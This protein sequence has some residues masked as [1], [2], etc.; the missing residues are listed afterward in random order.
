VSP[1]LEEACLKELGYWLP[2]L[3]DHTTLGK[4]QE[5]VPCIAGSGV[6][7]L[8]A[9]ILT[10]L[11]LNLVLKTP[12]RILLRTNQFRCRDFPK[13][14]NKVRKISW[15]QYAVLHGSA[16]WHVTAAQSRLAV[17]RRI[18]ETCES[19]LRS[20]APMIEGAG[21]D[22][23]GATRQQVH[24][25]F[26]DDECT[27][28]LDSSGGFLFKRGLRTKILDA[29]LRENLAAALLWALLDPKDQRP[30]AL[31]DPMT[32]SGCFPL[33][34]LALTAVNTWS[35]FPF[36]AWPIFATACK[37]AGLEGYQDFLAEVR[38]AEGEC[39]FGAVRGSD[40]DPKAIATAQ[41]NLKNVL[42]TLK[43]TP[44]TPCLFFQA[45]AT[46]VEALRRMDCVGIA[47]LNPP[48]NRRLQARE[49]AQ[50]YREVVESIAELGKIH[51]IGILVPREV[52]SNVSPP[53][54]FATTSTYSF[55]NGGIPVDFLVFSRT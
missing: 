29:P 46:D 14:F 44:Q 40:L 22:P 36:T 47:V 45:N 35:S 25:R 50:F 26:Q 18:L 15:E 23:E 9:S 17:E 42:S 55:R 30:S 48:Y 24:V 16:E 12:T 27:I 21:S 34:A 49:P 39:F 10:G 54:G 13:L 1:G 4:D 20:R 7:E 41:D 33:E 53:K 5:L 8:K 32:G 52:R 43:P 6:V 38:K 2:R 51:R 11:A 37:N 19:A 28:S 3:K 31:W